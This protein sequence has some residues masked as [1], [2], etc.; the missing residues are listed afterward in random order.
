M[1][2]EEENAVLKQQLVKSATFGQQLLAENAE[3]KQRAT[4][5]A[6]QVWSNS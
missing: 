3:L 4:E 5:D 6:E 2:L 1:T